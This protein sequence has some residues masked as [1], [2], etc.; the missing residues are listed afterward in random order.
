MKSGRVL[1]LSSV[2]QVLNDH[3]LAS[4]YSC[5]LQCI[6]GSKRKGAPGRRWKQ[7]AVLQRHR[8]SGAPVLPKF[9]EELQLME[10]EKQ[11]LG[12]SFSSNYVFCMLMHPLSCEVPKKGPW[13]LLLCG[14]VQCRQG[15]VCRWSCPLVV[16]I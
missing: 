4:V 6:L 2:F 8:T 12:S 10:D 14:Y 1:T 9:L 16:N 13:E 11:F 7:R 3:L 15:M 5:W